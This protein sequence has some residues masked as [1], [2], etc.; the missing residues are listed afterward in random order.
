MKYIKKIASY[1]IVGGFGAILVGGILGCQD[2]KE[3]SQNAKQGAFVVIQE[4]SEGKFQVKEEFPSEKT[5]IVLE[6]LDGTQKVLTQEE[7]DALMAQENAKIEAG[8]S[9]LTN[10]NAQLSSGLSLGE[11]ILA[12]AAGA[13]IGSWIG[14]KLFNNQTFQNQ[15]QEAYKNPS[16]YSRSVDSFNKAKTS[17]SSTQKSGKSGFFGG[18]KTSTSTSTSNFG[19]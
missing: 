16:A 18:S 7:M 1:S 3:I 19:G 9:N 6:K 17:S 15:R 5:R 11:A 8:T 12:S 2:N 13:I 10:Q 14:S 4:I